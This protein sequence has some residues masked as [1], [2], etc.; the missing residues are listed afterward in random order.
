MD[1][2]KSVVRRLGHGNH[3][4][5]RQH[6][7]RGSRGSMAGRHNHHFQLFRARAQFSSGQIHGAIRPRPILLGLI[8]VGVIGFLVGAVFSWSHNLVNRA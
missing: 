5:D 6:T 2:L 1:R 8:S 7:L 4:D 3:V